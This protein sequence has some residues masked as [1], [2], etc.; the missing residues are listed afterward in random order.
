MV[1]PDVD[2]AGELQA[3]TVMPPDP[4]ALKSELPP[5]AKSVNCRRNEGWSHKRMYSSSENVLASFR[6]ISVIHIPE[7]QFVEIVPT[8][9][10]KEA[11]ETGVYK[12]TLKNKM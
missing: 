3:S 6:N 9:K 7:M 11:T 4:T 2:L 10:Q 5:S 1:D 8:S 12:E